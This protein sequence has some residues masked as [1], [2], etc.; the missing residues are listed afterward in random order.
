MKTLIR[1]VS[2]D[3]RTRHCRHLNK[4]SNRVLS[5]S[6]HRDLA[7]VWGEGGITVRS[8]LIVVHFPFKV[9]SLNASGIPFVCNYFNACR[10]VFL[11]IK[12]RKIIHN[13][14]RKNE[15]WCVGGSVITSRSRSPFALT[16]FQYSC[17]CRHCTWLVMKLFVV[18]VW[19]V[20][21][22]CHAINSRRTYRHFPQ[23]F[24]PSL[25]AVQL[26]A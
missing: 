22:G 12:I 6:F 9:F 13:S 26:T 23:I 10:F 2:I 11:L 15:R 14:W 16:C 17:A 20:I 4:I 3:C 19:R 7:R 24:R 25:Y 21:I 5:A 8:W 18:F 1:C